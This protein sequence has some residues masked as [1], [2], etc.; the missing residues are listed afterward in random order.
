MVNK[1]FPL[2]L[3]ILIFLASCQSYLMELRVNGVKIVILYFPAPEEKLRDRSQW[4]GP[5]A[6]GSWHMPEHIYEQ[7]R[8]RLTY[9]FDIG[10]A[11]GWPC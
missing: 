10:A 2:S 3:F 4:L 7:F 6:Q 11:A 8:P 9:E 1:L 5:A